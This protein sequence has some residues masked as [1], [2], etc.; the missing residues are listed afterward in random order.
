MTRR[1]YK[2][3]APLTKAMRSKLMFAG[4]TTEYDIYVTK[5]A[6]GRCCYEGKNITVPTWAIEDRGWGFALYY[7]C[8][9]IAH[10]LAPATRGDVHGPKFMAA[11]ISICPE[12]LQYHELGYK[13]RLAA[14][15][16]IRESK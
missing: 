12:H 6:R 11:F 15:A 14:A 8:H 7:A 13:P 9:E 10:S 3:D 4:I 16:G 1:P 5:T 2:I